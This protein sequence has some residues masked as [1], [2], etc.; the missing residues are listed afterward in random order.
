MVPI[1]MLKR[2]VTRVADTAVELHRRIRS[3]ADQSV[4]AVVAHRDLVRQLFGNVDFVHLVHLGC[5]F[6]NEQP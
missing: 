1:D 6:I 2:F 5:G 3:I 4:G